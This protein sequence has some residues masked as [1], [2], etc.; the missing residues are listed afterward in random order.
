MFDR[1]VAVDDEDAEVLLVIE[2]GAADPHELFRVL[3]FQRDLGADAGVDEEVVTASVLELQ[4]SEEIFVG[5]GQVVPEEG[6]N[7]FCIRSAEEFV[8][9][10]AVGQQGFEASQIFLMV[11]CWWVY[12]K[13]Q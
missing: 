11:E 7:A 4:G 6:Q 9:G 8:F 12:Q 1:G 10:K 2:E 13:L 3:L 5:L